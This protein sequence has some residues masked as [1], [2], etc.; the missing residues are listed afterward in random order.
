MKRNNKELDAIL[1]N[2]VAGIRDEQLDATQVAAS[3][4]RVWARVSEEATAGTLMATS[5]ESS[6]AAAPAHI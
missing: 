2:A 5:N 4:S 6:A 1:D 3:T